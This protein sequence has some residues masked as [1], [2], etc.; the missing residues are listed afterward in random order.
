MPSHVQLP[1][2]ELDSPFTHCT[3]G[4]GRKY[5][6]V[7]Q[8]FSLDSLEAHPAQYIKLPSPGVPS[9]YCL[10]HPKT[11]HHGRSF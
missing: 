5:L 10:L 1:L 11:S 3:V 4:F 9:A 7:M 8:T 6:Q 2:S